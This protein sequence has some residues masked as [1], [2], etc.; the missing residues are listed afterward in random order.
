MTL[1]SR[2]SGSSGPKPQDAGH[3]LLE[4]LGALAAAE[5]HVLLDQHLGEDALQRPAHL[6]DVV[7]A[8][9]RAQ[10]GEQPPLH[11][12]FDRC[13]NARH[14]RRGHRSYGLCSDCG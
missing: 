8:D 6:V 12:V 11:P 1:S 14:C 9:R 13:C 2:S 3:D 7:G 5:R 4:Q 10:L